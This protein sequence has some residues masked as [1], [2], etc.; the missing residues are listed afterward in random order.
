MNLRRNPYDG[1]DAGVGNAKSM[2]ADPSNGAAPRLSGISKSLRTLNLSDQFY[3]AIEALYKAV[4]DDN[5]EVL[6]T[7]G[8]IIG[9][10]LGSGG[11]LHTFGSGH[12]SIL[13]QELVHRAGGLV[14]VSAIVDPTGGWVETIPGFGT[15]LV[16]RYAYQ[17]GL[18][19]GEVVIVISNSGKN[20]SPIE[21]A[22][23]CRDRGLVVVALTSLKTAVPSDGSTGAGRRLFQIADYT[24]D[25]A[26]I[27]GDAILLIPGLPD[28][29]G[30]PSTLTGSLV[31]NLLL[32]EIV[33]YMRNQQLEIPI[34]RSANLAGARAYN[35]ELSARYKHRLSRPL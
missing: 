23:D 22:L 26:G 25:N 27:P 24:L 17:Y 13:A 35:A 2:G 15:K 20:P 29:V 4:R 7:L 8:G 10:S 32:M 12:S 3:N 19:A 18:Q 11:V 16:Q 31:L 21:V 30:P 14:P 34:Y 5:R 1:I 33:Q 28:R 9:Q 6:R